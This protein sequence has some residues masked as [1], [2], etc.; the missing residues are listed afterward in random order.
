MKSKKREKFKPLEYKKLEKIKHIP[1]SPT[2]V[3]EVY[4]S[5]YNIIINY[6]FN[7]KRSIYYNL[8]I[9]KFSNNIL[10]NITNLLDN[11]INS[12]AKVKDMCNWWLETKTD[13][14]FN[15]GFFCCDSIIREYT[16]NK[17][18]RVSQSEVLTSRK[19]DNKKFKT[20][21]LEDILKKKREKKKLYPE[22]EEILKRYNKSKG[23]T[24]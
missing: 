2:R 4:S 24:T 6:I 20:E 15:F 7:N 22:E 19:V 17:R 16:I 18:S 12:E 1:S 5:L 11:S 10:N 3:K 13:K 14:D 21:I 9:P 23:R 8:K